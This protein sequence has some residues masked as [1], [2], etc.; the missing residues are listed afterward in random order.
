MSQWLL[1]VTTLCP[2]LEE[3]MQER[4]DAVKV[5]ILQQSGFPIRDGSLSTATPAGACPTAARLSRKRRGH[6]L[7]FNYSG[8]PFLENW[9][10][11]QLTF[12]AGSC[13]PRE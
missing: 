13:Y 11:G 4:S 12:L 8:L 3:D 2:V 5:P 6:N 9:S 7:P 1:C 10:G